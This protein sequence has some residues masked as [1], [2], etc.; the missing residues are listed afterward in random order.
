MTTYRLDL[1][2]DGTAYCGWQ[3]QP[4]HLSIQE[5]VERALRCIFPTESIVVHAAGRTDSGVHAL[6]QIAGF[7]IIGS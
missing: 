7:S 1:S 2:W 5:C 4:S 6:Q 3:R